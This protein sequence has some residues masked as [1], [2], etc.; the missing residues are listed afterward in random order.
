MKMYRVENVLI[1]QNQA[2]NLQYQATFNIILY[3]DIN[4]YVS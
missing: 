4:F 2:I 1:L 3:H